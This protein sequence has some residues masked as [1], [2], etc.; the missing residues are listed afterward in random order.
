MHRQPRGFRVKRNDLFDKCKIHVFE[1]AWKFFECQ[2]YDIAAGNANIPV[3]PDAVFPDSRSQN[4]FALKATKQKTATS[5][6]F[7]SQIYAGSQN[8]KLSGVVKNVS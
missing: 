7:D 3:S 5:F 6:M 8:F 4:R 1:P 2:D